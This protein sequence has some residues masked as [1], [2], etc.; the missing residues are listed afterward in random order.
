MGYY[1]RHPQDPALR[2][3]PIAPS[4]GPLPLS[5]GPLPLSV[6][7]P[8]ALVRAPVP[9]RRAPVHPPLGTR[10]GVRLPC[11]TIRYRRPPSSL[12]WAS[13]SGHSVWLLRRAT[14]LGLPSHSL[15]K[16]PCLPWLCLYYFFMEI[17]M[18]KN[19][20]YLT[21]ALTHKYNYHILRFNVGKKLLEK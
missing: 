19:T 4:V 2:R 7:H 3:A 5:V 17:H 6:R 13:P 8:C 10:P 12:R 16:Y 9:L 1:V 15:Y 21:M 11:S 14:M 20:K 18:A